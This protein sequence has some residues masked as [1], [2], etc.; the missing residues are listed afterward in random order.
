MHPVAIIAA[1]VDIKGNAFGRDIQPGLQAGTDTARTERRF[2]DH[3]VLLIT[4]SSHM[5]DNQQM[6]AAR[7]QTAAKNRQPLSHP[8][9][10]VRIIAIISQEHIT[11]FLKGE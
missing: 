6:T 10:L 7:Q 8:F 2:I 5:R 1:A 3:P 9:Q 11:A 4:V